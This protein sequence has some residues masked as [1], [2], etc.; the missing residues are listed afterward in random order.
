[1]ENKPNISAVKLPAYVAG[2]VLRKGEKTIGRFGVALWVAGKI[3]VE[4]LSKNHGVQASIESAKMFFSTGKLEKEHDLKELLKKETS[5]I[6]ILLKSKKTK[7]ERIA[8]DGV[9]GSGK[10]TL[11]KILAEEMKFKWKTLDYIDMNKPQD[12]SEKK[13]IFEHHRL[14]RTQNIE[15]FDAI[16]YIDEPI[17]FSK[18]KCIHRKRG[19]MN[20]DFFDYEKLKKIG[21][22]A[23]ASASGKVYTI[24]NT[25]LKIKIKPQKG[26]R[27]Y[28]N[29]CN[30]LEKKGIEASGLTKEELL[31][32]S[33]YGEAKKGLRSYINP[34]AYNKEFSKGLSAGL[35]TFFAE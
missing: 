21:E 14:L 12:F 11:S 22:K 13:T 7:V 15:D 6:K 33:V 2:W 9:P 29:L 17:E 1:M 4:E 30:E 34:N 25:Y 20:I 26:Y 19:G 23:F 28:K 32:L 5:A 31:F 18:K 35:S 27:S 16:I 24:P 8:I 3:T 10:S